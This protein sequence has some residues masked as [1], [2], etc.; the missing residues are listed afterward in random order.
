MEI[1]CSAR[2]FLSLDL[3]WGTRRDSSGPFVSLPVLTSA[4]EGDDLGGNVV[5]CCCVTATDWSALLASASSAELRSWSISCSDK[6]TAVM[7]SAV[8][9]AVRR[10]GKRGSERSDAEKFRILTTESRKKD[11]RVARATC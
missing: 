5:G 9:L 3:I 4:V 7:M 2:T 6:S 11:A 10:S 1:G 8:S